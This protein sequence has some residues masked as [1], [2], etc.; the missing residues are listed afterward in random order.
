[1]S[2]RLLLLILLL[3]PG[4]SSANISAPWRHGEPVGEASGALSRFAILHER[5]ALDLRPLATTVSG[6]VKVTVVYTI[7]NRGEAR[8]LLLTFVTPGLEH[9][10]VRVDGAAVKHVVA[11]LGEGMPKLWR[12]MRRTPNLDGAGALEY[13]VEEPRVALEFRLPTHPGARQTIEVRYDLVPSGYHDQLYVTHQVGY[14]LAPA[15]SWGSFGVLE[16]QAELPRGWQAAAEPKLERAGDQLRGRFQGLPADFL[17]ISARRPL[18][19]TWG[20]VLIFLGG[21]AALVLGPILARFVARRTTHLG[22][23]GA[24]FTALGIA[25]VCVVLVF[26]LPAGGQLLWRALLDA[27]QTSER[28]FYSSGMGLLL[29]GPIVAVLWSVIIIVFFWIARRRARWIA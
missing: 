23:A 8:E 2:T 20:W 13:G 4:A 22:G 3:L 17:A 28:Y 29:L 12:Q 16:V 9:G 11:S 14:L 5:L 21:V 25:L 27:T 1:V 19:L 10:E 6:R 7:H 15:R 24:F 26:A 18:E